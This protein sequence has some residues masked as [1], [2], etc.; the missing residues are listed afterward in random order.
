[1]LPGMR[2]LQLAID[3]A[4]GRRN[5]A[6]RVWVE[7]DRGYRQACAQMAQLDSYA[8]ET[9][10]KWAVAAQVRAAPEIV[11]HY[12]QF[13]GRL[14]QAIDLQGGVVADLLRQSTAARQVLLEAELRLV[15][16]TRL[17]EKRQSEARR[18]HAGQEQ[19]HSDE[20]AAQ[21]HRRMLAAR[22]T[23]EPG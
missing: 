19:R 15:S 18:R 10:S 11:H 22:Q 8:L 1:M 23:Q 17:L 9:E 6:S 5:E 3:V 4:T 2:G 21:Q 14:E 7:T 13:M 12:Y 20:L 16:L